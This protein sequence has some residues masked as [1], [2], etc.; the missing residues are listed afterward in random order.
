MMPISAPARAK[1]VFMSEF[2][3]AWKYQ[4]FWQCVFHPFVSGRVARMDAIRSMI[5]ERQAKGGVW[6]ATLEE[7]ALHVRTL[8]DAGQ[9][10]PRVHT[11]P[12]KDGR[13][14]GIPI[15]AAAE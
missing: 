4:T 9:Y 13:I 7:I 3:A 12:I 5:E 8:V 6:F 1:E 11:L 10:A 15:P 14:P 2:E